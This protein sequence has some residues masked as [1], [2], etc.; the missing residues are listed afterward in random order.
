MGIGPKAIEEEAKMREIAG[1]NGTVRLYDDLDE[2]ADQFDD[3]LAVA[4][5][6]LLLSRVSD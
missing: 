2:L 5:C 6:K 3:M 1:S 4:C